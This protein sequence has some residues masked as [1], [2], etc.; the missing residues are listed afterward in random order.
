MGGTL[1]TLFSCAGFMALVAWYSYYKTKNKVNDSTGYFL[2]GRG[3]TGGFIAGSLVLTNLS[4]EQLIGL[5]GQ[6]YSSNLTNMAWEVTAGFSVIIL[7]L[8]LLPRYLKGAFT[9]LPEFL[10]DRFD[11]GTRLLVVIL[12]MFGY[13]LV[14]IPSVLYSGAIAVLQFF[15][16]PSMLGITFEQSMWLSVWVI[17]IIGSVYAIFG[18]L[19]AVAISDTI[20]GVGL[21]IV[22]L[23]VPI[24]GFI[25]L[26][27]GN[28]LVGMK[29]IVTEHPEKLNSIGSK[30]D[31]VPFGTIFTGMIFANL[32]YWGTNQ[33]V[34]Q[35]TL[36]AKSLAEGQKG[37]LFTGF[38]KILVPFLM[39]MPGII[40]FHL[41]GSDLKNMDLAY[42]TLIN[43]IFPKFLNGFFLAV[44]LGAVFSSFNSLLNSAATMFTYDIYKVIFNKKANDKQ[45]IRVSQWFGVVL[46]LVT[47]FISPLL[48][49][50][51]D[52][53]WTVIREFT[54]FFNIPI[55]A[56]VLI[57]IFSKRVPAIGAKI[58]IISHVFIYYFLM[59]G[60]TTF[61]NIMIPVNFIHIQGGLFLV[62]I[63]FLLIMG[64]VKPLKKP[65][66]FKNK[67]V[68]KLTPWKYALPVSICLV[69][70]MVSTFALFSKIGLAVEGS[71]VSIWFW[72]LI[73]GLII[74]TWVLSFIAV[75][76]WKR[77][78]L[79]E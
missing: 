18:G 26:G 69:S 5:N 35:R 29:T 55:I 11:Q 70:S 14:T 54:G 58:V 71:I 32:F 30:E 42:P 8:I 47:F 76:S 24:L 23:I 72:P 62:E 20:N 49:Y 65:F 3:L 22:G 25:A 63:I 6:A 13:G 34:I 40:A 1:F 39:M 64:K 43:D 56:I 31:G 4:A 15:D 44:L 12:F 7:S 37:A 50:A 19:R 67:S 75:Q 66:V 48:I 73:F 78:Y 33:Y 41:Y 74:V 51:P 57:G 2:A 10:N 36:G 59:W 60:T 79:N 28:F 16:I 9:T 21:L 68:V 45:M 46:S 52:G 53:L 27:N 17:G 61:F 77:K 38:L